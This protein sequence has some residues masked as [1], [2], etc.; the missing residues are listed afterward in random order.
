M[1]RDTFNYLADGTRAGVTTVASAVGAG[2]S[3]GKDADA[4]NCPS[5]GHANDA[6]A[7]F[8]DECGK[9]MSKTCSACEQVNDGDAKFCSACGNRF[10]N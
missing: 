8:C 1:G 9:A 4:I 6:G 10:S 3:Q 2:L 7:K 5:C